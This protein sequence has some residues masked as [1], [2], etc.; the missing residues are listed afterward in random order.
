MRNR[1]LNLGAGAL[2]IAAL[3]I[4]VAV[5]ASSQQVVRLF[6]TLSG[7]S[8]T[9]QVLYA[10]SSGNLLVS[11]NGGI[12][13]PDTTCWSST[14]QDSYITEIGANNPG[15]YTNGTNCASGTLRWDWSAS[16]LS[17]NY[18]QA[19]GVTTVDSLAVQNTTAS[20][21][22]VTRQWSGRFKMCGTGY[23][24][25]SGL[26]EVDCYAMEAQPNTTAGATGAT[27]LFSAS[28]NGGAYAQT[29]VLGNTGNLQL[30][31]STSLLFSGR[32]RITDGG[33]D[34][35]LNLT[36]NA[37]SAGVGLTFSSD[38]KLLFNTRSSGSASTQLGS[39]QTTVPTCTTNCG[40]AGG[41][42]T[43]AGSDSDMTVTMGAGSPASG[44]VVVFNGTWAAN[45][46]C[47]GQAAKAGMA[48][49]KKPLTI[50]ATTGQLT[51]V[52]D[53]TAP[54]AADVYS[55]HCRATS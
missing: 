38:G 6:G 51:V 44:F 7:T 25:S 43:V 20:T 55:I 33:A 30:N 10:D 39:T 4:V 8:S 29:M 47:I 19:E 31:T 1:W 3:V 16:R 35:K 42:S 40:N 9:P 27:L 50:A 13:I 46:S 18:G 22:G 52:T 11:V 36:N 24:S 15:A 32:A 45:P 37:A 48:T 41:A 12:I 54:S 34:A 14:T 28:N 17:V 23:N 26:S 49:G 5:P 2:L 53:G 21:A